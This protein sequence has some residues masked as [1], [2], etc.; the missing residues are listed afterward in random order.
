MDAKR[1]FTNAHSGVDI[2]EYQTPTEYLDVQRLPHIVK[3]E[4]FR[5]HEDFID[6]DEFVLRRPVAT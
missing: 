1:K 4:P 3:A 6:T 2:D 5:I